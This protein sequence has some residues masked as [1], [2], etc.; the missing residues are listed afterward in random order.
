MLTIMKDIREKQQRSKE[1]AFFLFTIQN[2]QILALLLSPFTS[3]FFS[4]IL[5]LIIVFG[6][7]NNPERVVAPTKVNGFKLI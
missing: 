3:G 2:L 6:D 5:K 4:H 1:A 7:V